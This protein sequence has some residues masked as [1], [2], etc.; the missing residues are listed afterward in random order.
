MEGRE[1]K[2]GIKC[3]ERIGKKEEGKDIR[4]LGGKKW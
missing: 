4:L 3:I 2:C 1:G